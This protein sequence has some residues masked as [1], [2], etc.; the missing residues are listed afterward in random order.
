MRTT[1][2]FIFAAAVAA[3]AS[4]SARA[5]SIFDAGVRVG[6]QIHQYKFGTPANTDITEISAPVFVLVPITP[7]FSLDI[8][9]SY[10]SSHVQQTSNGKSTTSD[11][12]GLTDTQLRGTYTIGTDFVVLTAGVNLPTG[13]S[14]V[15][16]NQVIAAGLIASDFLAFPITNMGTGF[17]GTGG[18][19]VAR[20]L[21]DWNLGFGASMRYSAQYDPYAPS[22]GATPLHYQPGN[23]YRGRL[24]V[25][26]AVGTG[27]IAAGVTYSKFGNDN[28]GG[29]IY[30]TGDR[31]VTQVSLSNTVGSGDLWLSGWNLYRTAGTLADNSYLGH[32]NIASAQVGYS[33]PGFGGRVE[34]SLELRDWMQ[35]S[36]PSSI[37]ATVGVQLRFDVGGFGVVPSAGY[38][39]GHLAAQNTD[40]TNTTASLTGLHG[41]L[42]IRLR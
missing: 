30:N 17:G 16:P 21:G 37:L 12:S 38:S 34:P 14:R 42:A 35:A 8:G 9:T 26:R 13:Q 15:A 39:V 2:T 19:A 20:P 29:S 40:G 23:E 24:G 41:T 1:A 32:E 27:R 10:V 18:I 33:L 31:Y 11:I 3:T 22:G 6:P 36:L 25:D 28:I 4:A 7:T 5:Q